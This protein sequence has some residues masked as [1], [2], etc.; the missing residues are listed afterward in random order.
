MYLGGTI[1][2]LF[3]LAELSANSHTVMSYLRLACFGLF[4]AGAY[5]PLVFTVM[6]VCVVVLARLTYKNGWNVWRLSFDKKVIILLSSLM[7]GFAISYWGEGHLVRASYLPHTSVYE[8]SFIWMKSSVKMFVFHLPRIIL[9]ALLFAYPFF[10]SGIRFR[11]I[12]V[13]D[14]FVLKVSAVFAL[15]TA[16]SLIPVS[17]VMSEMGP[18]RSWT[19][20][21]LYTVLYA[22]F[23]SWYFGTIART[24]WLARRSESIH[25]AL[26]CLFLAATG[27]RPAVQAHQYA[28]AYDA[29][30][31]L[32]I[33]KNEQAVQGV[34]ALEQL[35]ASGWLHS[36]EISG[37]PDFY[38][39]RFLV[40]YLNLGYEIRR[41]TTGSTP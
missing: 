31:Q 19:Q 28:R 2:L 8:K 17:F 9:F 10:L 13:S 22:S 34:V 14:S 27:I 35:P 1:A 30:M 24:G 15:L 18:E 7:L 16:I 4:V 38:Q 12:R 32:L 25:V 11:G 40:E 23:I 36:A 29:R 21:S 5:E 37:E 39:N 6:L 26:A 33:K 20:I 41:D 3:C